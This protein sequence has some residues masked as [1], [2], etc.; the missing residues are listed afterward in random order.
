MVVEVSLGRRQHDPVHADDPEQ[1]ETYSLGGGWKLLPLASRLRLPDTGI[2]MQ[3]AAHVPHIFIIIV[4]TRIVAAGDVG[5]LG[6]PVS[7]EEQNPLY[8][9]EFAAMLAD[10]L[11]VG[12]L[13]IV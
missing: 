10:D 4:D 6:L 2:Q 8:S 3:P 11:C 12:F 5:Y 13:L 1:D 7:R 9:I